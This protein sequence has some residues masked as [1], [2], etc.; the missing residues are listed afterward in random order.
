MGVGRNIKALR[1]KYDLTQDQLADA[2]GVT[3]E[4]IVRW[5]ADKMAV[6]DRHIAKMVELYGL[7]PDDI[8]SE[9]NGIYAQLRG[10]A[11]SNTAIP[12][13]ARSVKGMAMGYVP[14]RGRV[15]MGTPIEPEV[16]DEEMVLAPQFLIDDDPDLYAC[17]SEGDCMNRVYPE[18]CIIFVSPNKEPQNGSVAVVT[19]DGIDTVMRRMFRTTDTLVLSPDSFN[20]DNR[21]IVITSDDNRMVEFKGKVV[22][23][24]PD[25]EME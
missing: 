22:W 16:Y 21:D 6:R 9:L 13:G 1:E 5:E 14:L 24:Q 19:I 7:E 15:H 3:R 18:G 8:R 10:T 17:T 2:L 4:S 23:F 20:P 11:Q 25:G 12:K